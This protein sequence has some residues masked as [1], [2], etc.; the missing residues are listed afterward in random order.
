MECVDYVKKRGGGGEGGRAVKE[1]GSDLKLYF[2]GNPA[3][4]KQHVFSPSPRWQAA[5][6]WSASDWRL[7][8]VSC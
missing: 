5:G 2:P 8:R 3:K 1:R 4:Q 6:K 7:L